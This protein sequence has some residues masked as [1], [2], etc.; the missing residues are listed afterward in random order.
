MKRR[1]RF[2][3]TLLAGLAVL[4]VGA[5]D[6]PAAP[7]AETALAT[8][9]GGCFW[10][11]EP[12][13]DKVSGV[14]STTVGYTGGTVVD[15]TY[16]QVSAGGTGHLEAVRV[17]YDPQQVSYEALL[18]V[19]WHNVDPTDPGG[20]FCD[21]GRQYTT[22]IFVHDDEQRALAEASK[23]RLESSG[24]LERPIV[25]AIRSAGPF[26]PAEEYHQDYYDKNPL[27]YRFYRTSCGRDR[28]LRRIWGSSEH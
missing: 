18:D 4:V 11:M 7:V 26:Y 21:R 16:E 23:R 6:E 2:A 1:R 5:S 28:Q 24:R 20:Q 8:F 25:T 3:P 22:A 27:R 15:P 10:C 17:T 9:A 14:L 19:F 13:F 12:P